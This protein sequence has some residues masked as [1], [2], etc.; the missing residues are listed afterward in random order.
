MVNNGQKTDGYHRHGVVKKCVNL[1]C[2]QIQLLNYAHH[3]KSTQACVSV[4]RATDEVRQRKQ[5]LTCSV[6]AAVDCFQTS[7]GLGRSHPPPH[8]SNIHWLEVR[9][10]A[11]S[12]YNL[13]SFLPGSLPSLLVRLILALITSQSMALVLGP[14]RS[15]FTTHAFLI[16]PVRMSFPANLLGSLEL[17]LGL[18]KPLGLTSRVG[19]HQSWNVASNQCQTGEHSTSQ[20]AKLTQNTHGIK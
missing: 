3:C 9:R 17:T 6:Q 18:V 10:L 2:V 12:Q 7:A 4:C 1:C 15:G 8:A 19:E 16:G 20:D 5:Q 13:L 14:H 11:W